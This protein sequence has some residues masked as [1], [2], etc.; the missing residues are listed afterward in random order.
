M[1]NQ[2]SFASRV[3]AAASALMIS[4]VLISTTVTTP[5]S[6]QARTIYVSEGA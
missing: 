4:L 2:N 6:A 5:T 1:T 3:A